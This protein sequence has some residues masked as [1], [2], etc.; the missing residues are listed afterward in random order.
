MSKLESLKEMSTV[1]AEL[2]K[3]V[4]FSAVAPPNEPVADAVGDKVIW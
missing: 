2:W 1:V 3:S 4:L